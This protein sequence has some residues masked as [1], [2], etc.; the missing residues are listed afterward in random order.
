MLLTKSARRS[1]VARR[2]GITTYQLSSRRLVLP[3]A[4]TLLLYGCLFLLVNS[5]S[6]GL[7]NTRLLDRFPWLRTATDALLPPSFLYATRQSHQ[8]DV[9][10]ALYALLMVALIAAWAWALW[11]VRPGTLAPTLRW[12]L[13]GAGL[14][15]VPLLFLPQIFSCDLAL[16]IYYGRTISE[17]G[18][19][20]FTVPP[21]RLAHDPVIS[22][23]R[24]WR[25]YG[26]AYG[27]VWLMLSGGLSGLTG[28]ARFPNFFAYKAALLSSHL[29]C[30]AAV[31][32]TLRRVRPEHAAWGA[33]FYGWN[34]LVLF[35]SVGNGHNDVVLATFTALALL[36]TAY[37][38][39]A[40]GVCFAVAAAM[41]KAP[42]VVLLPPLIL[43][44][45]LDTPTV[46]RKLLAGLTA[47]SVAVVSALVM[48]GPLWA[49]AAWLRNVRKNP[50][51]TR[52]YQ[53]LW[54]FAV[55][56]VVHSPDQQQLTRLFNDL[57][58]VRNGAFLAVYV[59]LI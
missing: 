49:G 36:A 38:R 17:Y 52:Y 54:E 16:Y 32:L 35:E 45:M 26:S 40:L 18:L 31:W 3:T 13:L 21:V 56:R 11:S 55:R 44:W 25:G 39:R 23:G 5:R 15:G 50:A 22:W 30:T 58:L 43:V 8:A 48:Y 29:L 10:A 34:P 6:Y 28:E 1:R 59:V 4:C 37:K 12:V 47:V 19:N 9:N 46:R 14:F 51:A 7:V 53:S 27:P 41:V 24:C 20:P 57:D 2:G 42:A 33:V